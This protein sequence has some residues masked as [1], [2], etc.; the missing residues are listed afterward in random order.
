MTLVAIQ[1]ASRFPSTI[2]FSIR[3]P[4]TPNRSVATEDILM[5]PVWH[6]IGENCENDPTEPPTLSLVVS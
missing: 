2:A 3:R 5:L 1:P 6:T 4:D